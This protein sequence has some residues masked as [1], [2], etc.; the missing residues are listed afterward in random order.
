MF[1]NK[2]LPKSRKELSEIDTNIELLIMFNSNKIKN[3]IVKRWSFGRG[4]N[5]G[6]IGSYRSRDYKAF[7]VSKNPQA[8]G[9]VDLILTGSLGDKI[10]ISQLG[11]VFE[12]KS[13]DYKFFDIG[14]KYGF[15]QF[16]LTISET[17]QL[18]QELYY[19][20][21]EEYTINIWQKV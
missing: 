11:D 5:G 17:N 9:R 7:K 10:F 16:N 15:E 13:N 3:K 21:M 1:Y 2:Q 6:Q 14:K 4:V 19:K 18:I 20:V 8:N 12:V